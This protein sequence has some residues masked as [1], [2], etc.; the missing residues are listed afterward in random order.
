M[1]E[2]TKAYFGGGGDGPGRGVQRRRAAAGIILVTV[3]ILLLAL[4]L[5][6]RGNVRAQLVVVAGVALLLLCAWLAHATRDGWRA[7]R[8]RI[9][10]S[11]VVAGTVV[12]V[13]V[14]GVPG[15]ASHFEYPIIRFATADGQS[16]EL[17]SAVPKAKLHEGDTVNVRYD[18]LDTEWMELA[19]SD[20]ADRLQP[21]DAFAVLIG[22]GL[23]AMV[24]GLRS[25]H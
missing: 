25:L 9:V 23:I 13:D 19:R 16:R 21:L 3:V 5:G 12:A 2:A 17:R 11:H 8:D 6:A 14:T 22:A 1:V 4:T 10:R 15:T 7:D 18:P 24:I 20:A